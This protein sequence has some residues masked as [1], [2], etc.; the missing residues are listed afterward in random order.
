MPRKARKNAPAAL[1][2][3]MTFPDEFRSVMIPS[4]LG[5]GAEK[6]GSIHV[7]ALLRPPVTPGL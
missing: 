3:H 4:T 2:I 1:H 5:V 6:V 7:V